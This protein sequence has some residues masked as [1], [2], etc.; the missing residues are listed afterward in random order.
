MN[1]S[2]PGLHF[3]KLNGYRYIVEI[4]REPFYWLAK[5]TVL[6]GIEVR[7]DSRE[8]VIYKV[9]T[10]AQGKNVLANWLRLVDYLLQE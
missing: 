6:P 8:E 3:A 5:T 9:E 2:H 4:K 1:S 7:G 10:A